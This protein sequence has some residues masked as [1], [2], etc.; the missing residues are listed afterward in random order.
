M[1]RSESVLLLG[2]Y[3]PRY[4]EPL[5]TWADRLRAVG[6][7][8]TEGYPDTWYPEDV[9]EALATP[10]DLVVYFGHGEPGSWTGLGRIQATDVASVE[11]DAVTSAETPGR[12]A[13]VAN[14]CCHAFSSQDGGPSMAEAFFRGGLADTVVGFEDDVRHSH[15]R[16][17]LDALLDAYRR[18]VPTKS[19]PGAFLDHARDGYDG[20]AV[21]HAQAT[22]TGI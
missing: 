12:H 6:C 18:A 7:S 2:F 17:T 5:Q 4:V 15:N 14:C 21:S 3:H 19:G 10:R 8:V 13:V 9:L 1:R 16:E 20:L 11:M 22:L